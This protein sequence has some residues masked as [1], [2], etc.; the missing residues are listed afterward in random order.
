MS[1]AVTTTSG[2]LVVVTQVF[3]SNQPQPQDVQQAGPGTHRFIQAYPLA[4]GAVQIMIGAL[5]LLLGI[6]MVVQDDNLGGF[7]GF[8]VWGAGIY[9]TSGALTVAAGKSLSR[10]L[11]NTALSFSVVSSVAASVAIFLYSLDVIGVVARC[12]RYDCRVLSSGFSGVLLVF[13]ILEFAVSL[14]VSIFACRAT[15]NCCKYCDNQ[16]PPYVYYMPANA[17]MAAQAPPHTVAATMA[18]PVQQISSF[19][20]PTE[21]QDQILSGLSEPPAYTG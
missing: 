8:F 21:N 11:V 6:V 14:T 2:G 3:P 15:C 5:V 4:V 9:I 20:K 13:H 10:C 12:R 19:S 16:Q 1:S 18:V 17:A 7:S